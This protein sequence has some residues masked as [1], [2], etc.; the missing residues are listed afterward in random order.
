MKIRFSWKRLLALGLLG[1]P[2][3]ASAEPLIPW[4]WLES[5]RYYTWKQERDD[6]RADWY[7]RRALDPV[8]SRQRYIKGKMWPPYPRPEGLSML[9]SHRFHTAH[10][11]PFPYVC[12]DRQSVREFIASQE[13]AGWVNQTTLYEF[14]FDPDTQLLNR[15]GVLHLQWILRSAPTHRRVLYV[16]TADTA[17]ASELRLTS[18]RGIAEEMVG[19][20]NVPPLIPRVTAPIGRSADEVNAILKGDIASQ[21]VPRITSAIGGGSSGGSSGTGSTP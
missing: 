13:D 21:P 6:A 4:P 9:P 18:V 5:N 12:Q 17:K 19:S 8:G 11:W 20:Q 15:S 3:A 2:A 1:I 16:Q 14:H 10:Y 7:A